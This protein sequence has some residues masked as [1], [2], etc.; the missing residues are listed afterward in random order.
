MRQSP[1]DYPPGMDAQAVTN[2]G[3][4]G[5]FGGRRSLTWMVNQTSATEP[6]Q[7]TS[8]LEDAISLLRARPGEEPLAPGS[9]LAIVERSPEVV[10]GTPSAREEAAFH[11]VHGTW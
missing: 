9:Y 6:S 8:R 1:L 2:A 4:M 3:S 7:T 5:V 10:L 11:L